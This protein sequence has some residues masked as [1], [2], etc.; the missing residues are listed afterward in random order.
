MVSAS[1]VCGD[2][3]TTI[4]PVRFALAITTFFRWSYRNAAC[5]VVMK[6]CGRQFARESTPWTPQIRGLGILPDARG[7]L[8]NQTLWECL[9]MACGMSPLW[10]YAHK[11]HCRATPPSEAELRDLHSQAELG[12]EV[13]FVSAEKNNPTRDRRTGNEFPTLPS[14]FFIRAS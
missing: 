14:Q 12:N 4:A 9:G 8:L 6:R 10:G 7:T 13:G 11:S 3:I 2:T 5:R 1:T